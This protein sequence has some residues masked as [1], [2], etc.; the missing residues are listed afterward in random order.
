MLS[1]PF[2]RLLSKS[3]INGR[4]VAFYLLS[5]LL[6]FSI[7]LIHNLS[8]QYSQVM[9]VP[10]NAESNIDGHSAHSANSCVIVARC[11][12][13]GFNLVKSRFESRRHVKNVF[14]SPDDLH[15]TEG[16]IFSITANELSGYVN[17]IFGDDIQL[18]SVVSSSVEF[19]FPFENHKKV[20]V[21]INSAISFKPQYMAVGGM[22]ATPDSV[23]VYGEPVRLN[24]IDKVV[25]A[26]VTLEDLS[27][28]AH[29]V[30]TIDVPAGLRSSHSEV[31]YALEVTRFVEIREDVQIGARNV[32]V[33]REL[34]V[35]P[36]VATV[37]Y[38]CA[39]PLSVDP[40]DNIQ[41]YVDYKDFQKS[42]NGRCVPHTS[43]LPSGVLDYSIEPQVFEC[44]ENL[45]K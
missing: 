3:N 26:N 31:S 39:F 38:R 9:S 19:R 12:T 41:F 6:A 40:S 24:N 4:D 29:G 5:L 36:S 10:V 34:S 7:W 25:T 17:E 15:Q 11:R 22:V 28:T 18:E 13:S 32:P 23:T 16:D 35:F 27:S 20:P 2:H 43:A 42:I 37:V 45:R 8:L 33:G 1:K 21:V 30:A 44:I 14:F